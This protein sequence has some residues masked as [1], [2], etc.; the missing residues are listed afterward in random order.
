MRFDENYWLKA[1]TEPDWY[2]KTVDFLKEVKEKYPENSDERNR[3]LKQSRHFFE[4]ALIDNKVALA[5]SGLDL[6]AERKPIDTIVVHHTSAEPGYRTSYMNAVHMLNIYAPYFTNPTVRGEESLKGQP[7]WSGH[8]YGGKPVFWA[9]H[10]LMRMDGSFERLLPDEAI[11]WHSGNWEINRRS[12]A[13]CLDND[14]ENQDPD[15]Q[16][17]QKLAA[18]IKKNYAWVGEERVLGHRECRQGTVCPGNGWLTG[19]KDK[20]IKYILNGS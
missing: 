15:E 3:L 14:Y 20:L 9:Y 17:L 13:I 19:W 11:G 8:V 18:H 16:I 7:L 12:I 10:W 4:Q 6:D 5:S 2:I 1:I